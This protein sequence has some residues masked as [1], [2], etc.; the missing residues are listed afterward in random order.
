MRPKQTTY[1]LVSII[2]PVFNNVKDIEACLM[3]VAN[4][5]YVEKEH[6]IIDGGSTDGTL[7]VIK[8]YASQYKH[9]KWVSEKDNGVYE[10]MNKGIDLANGDWLYFLGSDDVLINKT[11]F[12]DIFNSS[13]SSEYDLLYGKIKLKENGLIMGES[14]NIDNLKR[15]NTHHQATFIRRSVYS[16]LGLYNVRYRLCADWAFT[17]RCFQ[18]KELRIKYVDKIIAIYSTVGMSNTA[19]IRNYNPRLADLAF[20][21]DFFDLFEHFTFRERVRT[22]LDDYLP[23]YLTPKKYINYFNK[24]RKSI[25]NLF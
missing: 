21:S 19:N 11:V 9:I 24:L 5:S 13:D 4:Q 7:E 8:Q 12:K 23:K 6:W 2:T 3:S 17:I 25:F 1:E 22:Y 18:T 10:A 14:I 15:T 16:K 20:N